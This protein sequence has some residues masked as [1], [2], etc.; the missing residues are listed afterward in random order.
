MPTPKPQPPKKCLECG[1]PIPWSKNLAHDWA[2]VIYCS[3]QCKRT[4]NRE[5]LKQE[6]PA[7][8]AGGKPVKRKVREET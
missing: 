3:N 4:A 8:Y 1:A 6:Q 7:V 2:R 5:K